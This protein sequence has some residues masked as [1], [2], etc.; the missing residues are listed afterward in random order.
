MTLIVFG[1]G[2]LLP[3]LGQEAADAVAPVPAAAETTS[4][5]TAATRIIR[6]I[7]GETIRHSLVLGFNRR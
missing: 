1:T 6:D 7:A 4:A 5:A 2:T 3:G